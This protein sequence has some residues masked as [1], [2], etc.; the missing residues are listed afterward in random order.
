MSKKIN[1]DKLQKYKSEIKN[2]FDSYEPEKD[3]TININNLSDF[4]KINNLNKKNPFL[5]DSIKSLT[6]QKKEENEELISSDEFISYIDDQ[7]NDTDS[8]EGLKKIFSVFCEG[9]NK[10]IS[11]TKLPIIAKEL[12]DNNLAN[13]LMKLI[14][15]G[16]LFNKDI[17]FEEFCEILN[18]D[19]DKNLKSFN[20]SEE[21]EIHENY[22]EK[23][24]K[25][26]KK[27]ESEENVSSSSKNEDNKISGEHN[28]GEKSNKRYHR[29]Y[30]DTKNKPDNNDTG[31]NINNN[32][33]HTKYRKKK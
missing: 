28:E 22:K 31:N 3:G 1:N 11:W 29:R 24:N 18:D 2:S 10:N 27:E 33:A 21:Y 17:D 19:Y 5:Y 9:N 12:G 13:N 8:K 32:K 26:K 14:E 25:K 20:E 30:R 4:T 15:Q 16:K 7:L 6:S 23:K